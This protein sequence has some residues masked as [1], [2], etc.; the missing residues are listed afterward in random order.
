MSQSQPLYYFDNNATTRVAPEVIEAMLPYLAEQWGN[1]SSAYAHGQRAAPVLAAAR[2]DNMSAL[3]A[4]FAC[5]GDSQ[6]ACK[7]IRRERRRSFVTCRRAGP[8]PLARRQKASSC[9]VL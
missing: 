1:P 2:F 6:E 5:P 4:A 7:G 9:F 8:P 3:L